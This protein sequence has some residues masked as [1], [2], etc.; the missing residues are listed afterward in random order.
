[1]VQNLVNGPK[2]G[3][4]EKDWDNDDDEYDEL[5]VEYDELDVEYDENNWNDDGEE[6]YDYNDLVF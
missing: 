1:M 6:E 4:Q 5:D 3:K 2:N